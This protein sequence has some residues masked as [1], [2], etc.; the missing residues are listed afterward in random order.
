MMFIFP[1][2]GERCAFPVFCEHWWEGEVTAGLDAQ[3]LTATGAGGQC[4]SFT[5]AHPKG[6]SKPSC[7][8]PRSVA[9]FLASWVTL[10]SSVS[11]T[12]RHYWTRV[13]C[14]VAVCKSPGLCPPQTSSWYVGV[15]RTGF[16][17]RTDGYV[18]WQ[19]LLWLFFL[20]LLLL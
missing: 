8:F 10:F 14:L 3:N 11:R 6:R 1:Q 2:A 13:S 4:L 19:H 9:G 5:R 12:P 7:S 18:W 15:N 16:A 20:F 17:G